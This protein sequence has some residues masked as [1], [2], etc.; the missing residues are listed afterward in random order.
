LQRVERAFRGAA[1][2]HA[3]A[4]VEAQN[5]QNRQ[6]FYERRQ[7]TVASAVEGAGERRKERDAEQDLHEPVLELLQ[8]ELQQRR[9]R[10]GVLKEEKEKEK[11]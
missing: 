7:A 11:H 5:C 6:R 10:R 3:H 1:L 9:P 8:H 2:P 4:R